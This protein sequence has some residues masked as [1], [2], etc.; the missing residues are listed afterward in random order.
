MADFEEAVELFEKSA[1]SKFP[2]AQ[3]NL[4]L[5][6]LGNST[7]DA[8][9]ERAVSLVK[10]SAGKGYSNAAAELSKMY[11]AGELLEKDLLEA[12]Y[13]ASKAAESEGFKELADQAAS[14]LTPEQTAE[15]QNRLRKQ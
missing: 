6:L 2:P 8:D 10:A 4:A 14:R 1:A 3:L 7:Q 5:V 11:A 13:W 12:A 15:L 9:H